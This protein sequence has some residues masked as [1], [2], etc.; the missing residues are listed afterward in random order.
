MFRI[1]MLG[2]SNSML[3]Y[4]VSGESKY[5]DL[6]EDAA[7]GEKVR[8]PSDDPF[9]SKSILDVNSQINKL[10]NYLDNM[11]IAQNELD[12]FDDAMSSLTNLVEKATDLTVQAPNGSYSNEDMDYIKI[13]IDTIIQSVV[14]LA[15][16]QYNG[17]YIFSGAAT[18]TKTYVTDSTTGDITYQGTPETGS[19]QRY[20]TISDGITVAI[21]TTGDQ[22]F[23]SYKA[24][25]PDDPATTSVNESAPEVAVGL[26][27]TLQKISNAL[28]DYDQAAVSDCL[29]GLDTALDTVSVARTKFAS[30]SN[31]FQITQDSIDTSITQLKAY[32]S[33]LQDADLSEV[34]SK[35]TAQE[36]ALQATYSI[37]SKLLSGSSLLDYL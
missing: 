18:S 16:T 14:D 37:T 5:Y 10:N 27:G 25:I 3:N 20:T 4:I 31:R 29:S 21:N 24:A 32:K 23:G 2:T 13:Q 11:S 15:N 28:G 1:T 12:V 35:L 30:I 6:S 9:A 36:T 33:D 8:K 22:V 34:L 7:S 19:Y 17:N 26:L